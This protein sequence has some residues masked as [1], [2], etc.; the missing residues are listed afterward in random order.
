MYKA[1]F[2]NR[3]NQIYLG[4]FIW[5]IFYLFVFFD[6]SMWSYTVVGG[7]FSENTLLVGLLFQAVFF[8]VLN[9]N[10]YSVVIG[11]R[12]SVFNFIK[13]I[14]V[15]ILTTLFIVLSYGVVRLLGLPFHLGFLR[16]AIDYIIPSGGLN[17]TN[18]IIDVAY[19]VA[20]IMMFIYLTGIAIFLYQMKKVYVSPSLMDYLRILLVFIL[21]GAVLMHQHQGLIETRLFIG[22]LEAFNNGLILFLILNVLYVCFGLFIYLRS[23]YSF[24]AV[25]LA[26]V[27]LFLL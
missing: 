9:I 17:H 20:S 7:F 23:K 21:Y 12:N 16:Y 25:F 18:L 24:K 15:F 27:L 26:M 1:A 13:F 10:L 14:D 2:K 4:A 19:I 3:L 6:S 22:E 8:C 5:G 11:K